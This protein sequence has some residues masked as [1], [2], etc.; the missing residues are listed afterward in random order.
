MRITH[1]EL[2][3]WRNFKSANIDFQSRMFIFGPTATGK[4]N[5][6]DALRFLSEVAAQEGGLQRALSNRR[7]ISPIRSLFARSD[8]EVMLRVVLVDDQGASWDY[9][10]AFKNENPKAKGPKKDVVVVSQE[11]VKKDGKA[12]LH[13]PNADDRKDSERLSE[14][15]LEQINANAAF[16]ALSLALRS[17]QYLHVVPQQVRSANGN[18][19]FGSDLLERMA[20]LPERSRTTRLSK[21]LK[22]LQIAVPQLAELKIERDGRG[23]PHLHVRY[24]HW[25]PRGGWQQEEQLSDGTT[26]LLALLWALGDKKG[27]PLLLEEP[28]L[29]LHSAVAANIPQMMERACGGSDGRQVIVTTHSVEMLS[30]PGVGADELV[31]LTPSDDGTRVEVASTIHEVLDAMNA[32]LLASDA[33]LPKTAPKN[34]HQLSLLDAG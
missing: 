4:S 28:E 32:G 18:R 23:A 22:A 9:R 14:T 19:Q 20:E 17:M 3:N 29:S 16:R 27:G 31:L 33:V 7:G 21:I 2:K 26:R 34:V 25:R 11:V 6:L 8:P 12:M 13:R 30:D 10:L 1:L 5:I 15:H 24:S